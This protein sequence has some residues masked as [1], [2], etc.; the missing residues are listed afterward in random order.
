MGGFS[1][2][3]QAFPSMASVFVW[4]GKP[5]RA[6]SPNGPSFEQIFAEAVKKL[7]KGLKTQNARVAIQRFTKSSFPFFDY[8]TAS[9]HRPARPD[10]SGRARTRP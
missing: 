8:F 7:A 5:G 2:H 6:R 4:N 3:K 1:H 10:D 9:P